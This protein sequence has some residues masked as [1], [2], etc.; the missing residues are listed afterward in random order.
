MATGGGYFI[1]GE[2]ANKKPCRPQYQPGD[3]V[4]SENSG[5]AQSGNG[6]VV[7]WEFWRSSASESVNVPGH[8]DFL[9]RGTLVAFEIFEA[10]LKN[11]V[12]PSEQYS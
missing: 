7:L 12:Q 2:W 5:E 8:P 10:G 6:S 4:D 11:L 3:N 1:S 9:K